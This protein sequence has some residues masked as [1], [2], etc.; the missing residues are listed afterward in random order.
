M[1]SMNTQMSQKIIT[2]SGLATNNYNEMKQK[3]TISKKFSTKEQYLKG[4]KYSN[5]KVNSYFH[6][7]LQSDIKI[8]TNIGNR[9]SIYLASVHD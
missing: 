6:N 7:K 1:K 5:K 3:I 9:R 2:L 4:K 8:D